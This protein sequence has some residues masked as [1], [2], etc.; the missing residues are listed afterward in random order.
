MAKIFNKKF[1]NKENGKNPLLEIL[2]DS[3]YVKCY[4]KRMK[5]RDSKLN[6]YQVTI[7]T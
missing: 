2:T 4:N 7:C 6:K 5:S 3:N 1:Y